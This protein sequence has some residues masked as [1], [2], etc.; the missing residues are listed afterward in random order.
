MATAAVRGVFAAL[1]R[2]DAELLHRFTAT[3]DEG[4]FA[5]LVRRHGPLVLGVCRRVV[6]DRHLADDAFQAAF[7]VLAN[8]ATGLD[9][10]RP[11]GPWLYGVAFRVALRARLMTGRRRRRE[12]LTAR[13]P[14]V[15]TSGDTGDSDLSAVVDEEIARL[16]AVCREAVVL[17]EMQGLSRKDA[18]RK[19]GV[20]EGTLSSRL[21]AARKTLAERLRRRGVTLGVGLLATALV[22]AEL[23]AS[24]VAVSTGKVELGSHLTTLIH[25]ATHMG[26]LSKLKMTAVA[27]MVAVLSAGGIGVWRGGESTAA[28]VP[29][30][31]KDD[32][33][34][35]TYN[36]KTGE[37]T[38][39]TP[40][41]KRAKEL[42]LKDGRH[43]LGFTPDGKQILF[44]GK[45]G[46]LA[47]D[48]HIN[49]LN[50]DGL[51][52]H[53]RDVNDKT[54]G[55]DTG[56]GYLQSDQFVWSPDRKQVVRQRLAK[57][58]G[59]G[60]PNHEFSNVLF[61]VATKKETPIDVP[62]DHQI[63]QW[64]EDGKTWRVLH[65]NVG[66][67]PALPNYRW[68]TATAADKP[69]LFPLC[70]SASLMWL[71]PHPNG[72]TFLATG[73]EFPTGNASFGG[74]LTIDRAT[75]KPR[76]IKRFDQVAFVSARW[77]PDGTRVACVKYW[78]DPATQTSVDTALVTFDADGQNETKLIDLPNDGQD[79]RLLGWFPAKPTDLRKRNAPVPKATTPPEGVIVATKVLP[80]NKD[81]L[82][83]VLGTDGKTRGHLPVG[84]LGNVQRARVSPDGKRLA[85][86]RFI[87]LSGHQR[88]QYHYPQDVY[89]VDLPLTQ[90]PKEPTFKGVLDPQIAWADGKT[91]FLTRVADGT[92]VSQA[93]MAGKVLPRKTVRYDA[94]TKK[95]NEV[96]L[97]N[98]HEVQDVSPDGKTLLTRI[99]VWNGGFGKTAYSSFLV[100]LDTLKAKRLGDEGDGFEIARLSP[101]GTRVV[102]TRTTLSRSLEPG[103]FLADVKTGKAEKVPLAKEV[104]DGL[105][106]G[107][108]AWAPDGKR[109]AVLWEGAAGGALG[110]G[111][112]GGGAPVPGKGLMVMDADGKNEKMIR[113]FATN[114][115]VLHIDWADPKL[116]EPEKP[117]APDPRRKNAPVPKVEARE[118]VIAL[119]SVGAG[120]LIEVVKP[121]GTAVT[122]LKQEG[123]AAAERVTVS[124][125]DGA[126]TKVIV[127]REPGETIT[128]LDWW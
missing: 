16:S 79:T 67:D 116:A 93:V 114:E 113:T 88:G 89:V 76:E 74:V 106:N 36:S 28:P 124:D 55:T 71:D 57:V 94:A 24:T 127:K 10:D 30:A 32:G 20:A 52:L 7:V 35:W 105:V 111:G 103:V 4:A 86:V 53:L 2:S 43:F 18:A 110:G 118:G 101:D 81:E 49:G 108:V 48:G 34:I 11:L 23:L 37:L 58:G 75:G 45:K 112:G 8:K 44:A 39:L 83:E 119:S 51:T 60:A 25:G 80:P 98:G 63:M 62:T 128:G 70:D 9:A 22:P 117:A 59:Q 56:L 21:A 115:S 96:E 92:D 5:E 27:V 120:A 125:A 72:M 41:G 26:L 61:D 77:S 68:L 121:D 90:P 19:L 3:R 84:D 122:A 126:N 13:V 97:P 95:E 14:D 15:P 107:C 91:L 100:P 82:V 66:K 29:K 78:Y 85:F 69:K 64:A 38:A 12:T 99:K 102:G 1:A 33:L 123:V 31:E 109:L 73:H 47:E 42:T 104:E 6:S 54:E 40:D 87:P 46:K 17:C 65:N 50:L